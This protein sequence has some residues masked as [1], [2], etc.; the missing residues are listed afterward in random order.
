MDSNTPPP[1]Q[2]ITPPPSSPRD[3]SGATVNQI[4][5]DPTMVYNPYAQYGVKMSYFQKLKMQK[6][7]RLQMQTKSWFQDKFQTVLVQRNVLAIISLC[8]L[9]ASLLAVYTVKSLT[10]L[11]SVEPF[12]IQIEEKSGITQLVE[13][14]DR[15][16]LQAPEALDNYFLWSYVRARETYHP[17]DQRRNWNITRIM[18]SKDVFSEYLLDVS[19]NNP[20]SA[21]AVLGGAGTRV[22]SDPT[23]TYLD[24]PERKVAQVRFLVEETFKKVKTRYPKIATIEYKY[25]DL[26]LKRAERLVNPL[27]F[28]SL[29]YRLDEEVVK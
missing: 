26:E 22:L 5:N 27:G 19:P 29:S 14:L 18:S 16:K 17:A 10:P 4:L 9:I 2:P 8:S 25:F 21:R 28:Q 12:I 24:D 1:E 20:T 13:P 15:S 7:I 23:V 11:K 6:A 3:V